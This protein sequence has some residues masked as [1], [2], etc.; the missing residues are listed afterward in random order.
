MQAAQEEWEHIPQGVLDS[1]VD[2]IPQWIKEVL[3]AHGGHTRW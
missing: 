3:R 1:W 2:L